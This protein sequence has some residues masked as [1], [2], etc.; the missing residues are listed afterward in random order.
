LRR[1]FTEDRDIEPETNII[2][3]FQLKHL[4]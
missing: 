4:G 3:R 2:V 1:T